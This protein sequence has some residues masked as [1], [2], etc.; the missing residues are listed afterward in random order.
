VASKVPIRPTLEERLEADAEGFVY[1]EEVEADGQQS[2]VGL[3]PR[4]PLS[5]TENVAIG[6]RFVIV[7]DQVKI[8]AAWI[9]IRPSRRRR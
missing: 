6:V 8:D 7:E 9:Y 3:Q 1:D 5:E 4:P 2:W